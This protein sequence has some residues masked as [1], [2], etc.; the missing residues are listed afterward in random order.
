MVGTR[1]QRVEWS[2]GQASRGHGMGP[3]CLG[4]TGSVAGAD[5]VGFGLC[6]PSLGARIDLKRGG[7]FVFECSLDILVDQSDPVVRAGQTVAG[8]VKVEVEKD[9]SSRGLHV[10]MRWHT[11]GVRGSRNGLRRFRFDAGGRTVEGS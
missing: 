5:L 4:R 6:S 9:G 1:R 11:T 8:R 2:G 3:S 7:R 10:Q